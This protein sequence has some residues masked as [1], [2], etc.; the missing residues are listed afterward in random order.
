[1][2][3]VIVLTL[4]AAMLSACGT[5][6]PDSKASASPAP[7]GKATTA[8]APEVSIKDGTAKLLSTAKQLRKAAT[9]G[10]EAKVKELGPKIEEV[11]SSFEDGVKPKYPDMYEQVEKSLNPAVSA[12]KA[13]PIDK[14]AVLKIDNQLIQV[15]FD[16][17]AKL[18]TVDQIKTGASQMLATTG[19]LK[20]EIAAGNDAKVKELAPK[21]EDVWKTF[22]DGVPPRSAELY[23]K[24]EKNL[25]PEV[26][27]SQKSPID[28]QVLAQL[29]DGLIQALNELIQT[30]K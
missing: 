12:T 24:I 23:E 8:K 3:S 15:L 21:L 16:L 10:D 20:K 30:I 17:S 28:K 11:W 22:E 13:S 1:M 25:N 18:I 2:M 7:E 6:K 27:G 14:D 5:A 29:N 26:A 19:D 9:A 4:S